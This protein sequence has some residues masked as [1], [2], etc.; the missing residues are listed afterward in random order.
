M[1]SGLND[2]A[3]LNPAPP[4]RSHSRDSLGSSAVSFNA[5]KY[6]PILCWT[7][8]PS[9]YTPGS[10]D[11]VSIPAPGSPASPRSPSWPSWPAGKSTTAIDPSSSSISNFS[12]ISWLIDLMPTPGMPGSPFSRVRS[13]ILLLTETISSMSGSTVSSSCFSIVIISASFF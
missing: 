1:F 7:M 9:R 11:L 10:Q 13:S 3:N 2:L 6:W 4:M 8:L 12:G 5:L